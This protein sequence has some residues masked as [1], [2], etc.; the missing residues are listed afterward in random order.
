ML[1]VIKR[2][3]Y[4]IGDDID[5]GNSNLT[6]EECIEIIATLQRMSDK[7]RLS[8]YS[9]CKYLNISRATFDNYVAEGKLP[10]GKKDV[11][12]KELSWSKTELDACAK[13]LRK[14]KIS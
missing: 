9:A 8:K 7:S 2:L 6:E 3:I 10:K 11:G 12:Y 14:K 1:N 5:S 13:N 4:K